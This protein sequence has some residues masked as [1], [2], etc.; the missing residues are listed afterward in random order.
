MAMK[1]EKQT[2]AKERAWPLKAG[3]GPQLKVLQLKGTE[4]CQQPNDQGN[5]C[6]PE[7][8]RKE[9]SLADILTLVQ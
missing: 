2:E 5:D 4:F 7:A 6:F 3:N 1:M 8:A 9:G